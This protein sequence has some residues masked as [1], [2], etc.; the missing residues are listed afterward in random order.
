MLIYSDCY[1]KREKSNHKNNNENN[2]TLPDHIKAFFLPARKI[3]P[4]QFKKKINQI[5]E[6]DPYAPMYNF[7][8]LG[9]I[10][11]NQECYTHTINLEG[12]CWVACD[13]IPT[14]PCDTINKKYAD[15][16]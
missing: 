7:K 4:K 14:R 8:D 13:R 6:E 3:I 1:Q 16:V 5:L 12:E 15:L 11:S 10:D 9:D 2:K